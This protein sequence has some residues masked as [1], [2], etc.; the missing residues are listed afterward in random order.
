MSQFGPPAEQGGETLEDLVAA[1]M[2][3]LDTFVNQFGG[4]A[5]SFW[6]YTNTDSPVEVRFDRI[7]HE[8][9]LVDPELGNLTLLEGVSTVS[10]I[11][12][13]SFAL[14]PWAAKKT[15][16]KMLRI[17]PTFTRP[18][19][20]D[21]MVPEMSLAA[22][23]ALCMSAK[24][25]HSDELDAAGE[26]G[27]MAH[28]WIEK[29]ILAVLA[30]DQAAIQGLMTQM[31]KDPRA[32]NCCIAA[33]DW[34]KA[35]N[36]RWKETER[37][38]FSKIHMCSGTMDGL[39]VVDSCDD[40]TCCPREFKDRLTIADWKTSN[41]L[42]IEFLFQTAAYEA[43]YEEEFRID[44]QDR[45]VLRLGK[46]DGEFEPWHVEETDFEE[47][48]EGFLACLELSR[49]KD[50]IDERI[51]VRKAETRAA[52]KVARAEAKEAAKAA[53]KLKKAAEKA[54]KKLKQAEEKAKV[55]AE[56]KA[57]R[58]RL[59]AETKL[60]KEAKV[61]GTITAGQ[62]E[63]TAEILSLSPAAQVVFVEAITNPPEPNVA[64]K[65]AAKRYEIVEEGDYEP[66]PIPTE[67]A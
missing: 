61:N 21:I 9:F 65:A 11:I 64:L 46:E 58:E 32:T 55:K 14:I 26:I 22:F 24:T 35:H 42:Y 57:E 33:L 53:E 3:G 28:D 37:K 16:E 19:S 48:F 7:Y 56:A 25:A 15:V 52:K 62:T 38:V 6:F 34:M 1:P 23:T 10:H 5:E 44:I 47:D 40:P 17:I 29:Y 66:P 39:C 59:R 2:G 12:D 49:L 50:R 31:C 8:Y 30:D 4:A 60:A 43:F 41:Y 45:W 63:N 27:S 51:R 67:E 18:I 36:V 20:G 13:R 54:E